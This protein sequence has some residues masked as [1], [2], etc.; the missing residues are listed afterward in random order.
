VV[1]IYFDRQEGMKVPSAVKL[2]HWKEL[3]YLGSPNARKKYYQYLWLNEM[4]GLGDKRK[5]EEKRRSRLELESLSPLPPREEDPYGTTYGLN[6]NTLF[7]RLYDTTVNKFYYNKMCNAMMFSRPLVIDCG[8]DEFMTP[9]EA[10]NCAKQLE[11]LITENRNH[12][13]PFDLHFMNADP[14]SKLIDYLGRIIPCLYDDGYPINI[15]DRSYLDIFPKKQLVYLSPHARD[16][17]EEWSEDEVYIVGAMVDKSDPRPFSLAKAKKEDLKMKKLP[18]DDY[19]VWGL[20]SK[21]LTLNQMGNILLDFRLQKDWKLALDHV[22][23]RKLQREFHPYPP[24]DGE[25]PRQA[26]IMSQQSYVKRKETK[27]QVLEDYNLI[28]QKKG[29]QRSY[30]SESQFRFSGPNKGK[31]SNQQSYNKPRSNN[32]S[33]S[34]RYD[35]D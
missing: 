5:K 2:N 30:G 32:S 3:L 19:L 1:S 27:S 16:K 9:R 17:L 35:A 28:N 23:K 4:K 26:P 8:Y 20:G 24:R 34:I 7:L 11:L 6:R 14:N 21:S 25:E 33:R 13:Q 15:T 29:F 10:K 12:S 22:P 18:L 31:N